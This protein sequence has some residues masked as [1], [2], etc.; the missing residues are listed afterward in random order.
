MLGWITPVV[1]T[2]LAIGAPFIVLVSEP[3]EPAGPVLVIH[4]PWQ[5]GHA[6]VLAAGGAPVGPTIAPMGLLADGT[7]PDFVSRLQTAGA[8]AVLNGQKISEICG[9]ASNT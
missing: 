2:V 5:D 6:L 7:S 8:I 4:A 3:V 1:S 9:Y